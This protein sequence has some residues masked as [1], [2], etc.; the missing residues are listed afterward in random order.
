MRRRA[1]ADLVA[2]AF[3]QGETLSP[4]DAVEHARQL[5]SRPIGTDAPS[6]QRGV[7]QLP[8]SNCRATWGPGLSDDPGNMLYVAGDTDDNLEPNDS[9]TFDG[10]ARLI[11]SVLSRPPQM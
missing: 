3:A 7:S 8:Q 11:T 9:S 6:H 4:D 2:T 10:Y 5:L 1:D